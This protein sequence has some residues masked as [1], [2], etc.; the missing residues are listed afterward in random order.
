MILSITEQNVDFLM[1]LF[2][3]TSAFG[4]VG[5]SM[6]LTPHLTDIGR[7]VITLTMFAGRVGPLTIAFALAQ[8]KQK[9]YYRFPK[10]KIMIG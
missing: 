8:R 7:I 9:E 5:L 3:S 1:I 4:T 2:E 10:G 6:G